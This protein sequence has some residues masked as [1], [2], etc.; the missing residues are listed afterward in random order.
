MLPSG[1]EASLELHLDGE[2]RTRWL[3][4]C[5]TVVVGEEAN[6]NWVRDGALRAALDTPLARDGIQYTESS[7]DG[8]SHRGHVKMMSA[9]RREYHNPGFAVV[10]VL[11]GQPVSNFEPVPKL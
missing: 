2:R 6:K 1:R 9:L 4:R 7:N 10:M 8:S 11:T 5:K 3:L